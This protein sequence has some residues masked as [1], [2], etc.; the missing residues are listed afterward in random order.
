MSK[1]LNGPLSVS[2]LLSQFLLELKTLFS[3]S[4]L[5]GV[6]V[7]GSLSY[8]GFDPSKSDIDLVVL[9]AHPLRPKQIKQLAKLHHS[10]AQFD[11]EWSARLECSYIPVGY[12]YNTAPPK[13]PRPYFNGH[14]YPAAPYGPEW[15]INY[16]LIWPY[17]T[18]QGITTQM[19]NLHPNQA[20]TVVLALFFPIVKVPFSN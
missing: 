1:K 7:T 10:L 16:A 8:G 20:L 11:P 9:T 17:A 2:V 15:A 14:F 18:E 6:Y 19:F 3:Y 5:I 4:D 13:S 12:F